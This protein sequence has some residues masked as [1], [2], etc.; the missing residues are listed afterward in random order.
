MHESNLDFEFSIIFYANKSCG[1][2]CI[3]NEPFANIEKYIKQEEGKYKTITYITTEYKHTTEPWQSHQPDKRCSQTIIFL[4]S[5][6]N[7]FEIKN[8]K[9]FLTCL[10][11]IK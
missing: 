8:E 9:M 5:K 2:I 11:Y 10:E 3:T 7:G 6:S 4:K 1:R